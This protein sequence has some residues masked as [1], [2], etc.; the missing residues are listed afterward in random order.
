MHG[1][2]HGGGYHP[3][4]NITLLGANVSGP[5]GLMLAAAGSATIGSGTTLAGMVFTANANS[6]WTLGTT[7]FNGDAVVN[8]GRATWGGG[9]VALNFGSTITNWGSFQI[10]CDQ[11]M[12]TVGGATFANVG[13]F[14]KSVASP[15]L[16]PGGQ[17]FTDI[18]VTFNNFIQPGVA[19]V[20]AIPSVTVNAD[21]WLKLSGTGGRTMSR[22]PSTPTVCSN[23]A[24]PGHRP[25]TSGRLSRG[26]ADS[27]W[28]ARP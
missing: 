20:A 11:T 24:A 22:S 23:S 18:Q 4:P 7:T 28:T 14:E 21:A 12:S 2:H 17:G 5:G 1:C 3:A 10:T 25:C 16:P 15:L 9:D 6:S 19:G 26:R 8:Y 13:Y 27:S